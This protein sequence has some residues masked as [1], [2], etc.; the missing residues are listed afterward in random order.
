VKLVA[1]LLGDAVE[2]EVLGFHEFSFLIM[3][4]VENITQTIL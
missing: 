4:S 1:A 2:V 3:A